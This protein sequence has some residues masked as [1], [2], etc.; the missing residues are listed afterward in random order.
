MRN[1]L[2]SNRGEQ[3]GDRTGDLL[4]AEGERG[5]DLSVDVGQTWAFAAT[6]GLM[7]VKSDANFL[8]GRVSEMR[9]W[10]LAIST[11]GDNLGNEASEC[12]GSR[13]ASKSTNGGVASANGLDKLGDDVLGTGVVHAI[14]ELGNDGVGRAAEGIEGVL[15]VGDGPPHGDS[16]NSGGEGGS[17]GSEDSKDGRETHG[18]MRDLGR[19]LWLGT[20][21]SVNEWKC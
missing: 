20:T 6:L 10:K 14:V 8:Q 5:V 21:G 3:V 1:S 12:G 17:T 7:P 4:Q 11:H 2:G 15:D 13:A 18:E 19:L 9:S 16:G